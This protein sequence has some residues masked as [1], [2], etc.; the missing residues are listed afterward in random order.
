VHGNLDIP[1]L[2]G[3]HI[4]HRKKSLDCFTFYANITS[5]ASKGDDMKKDDNRISKSVR[6]KPELWQIAKSKAVLEGKSMQTLIEELLGAYI[7]KKRKKEK[8]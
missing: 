4:F 8:T 1:C 6:V 7:L 2:L 3:Y 5:K